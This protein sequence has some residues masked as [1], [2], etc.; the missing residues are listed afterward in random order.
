M[1]QQ[2]MFP[3]QVNSPEMLLQSAIT[4]TIQ[5]TIV[6]AGSFST[7]LQPAPNVFSVGYGE[8]S[9]LIYYPTNPT[10][11][12]SAWT[13]TNCE[14][15][16]DSNGTIGVAKTWAVNTPVSRC[17]TRLDHNRFKENI[18]DL[19]ARKIV[20]P[21]YDSIVYQ[22]GLYTIASD[23]NGNILNQ[24]LIADKN[25]H[26]PIQAAMT[27]SAAHNTG[28][29]AYVVGATVEVAAGEY[30]TKEKLTLGN[31]V[32]LRADHSA[33]FHPDL[34]SKTFAEIG[35]NGCWD[36]GM[37][38]INNTVSF[39][40]TVFVLD[41]EKYGY[42]WGYFESARIKNV[43]IRN[44]SL[45]PKTGTAI[46]LKCETYG[47]F[48]AEAGTD[49]THIVCAGLHGLVTATAY[50]QDFFWCDR[51]GVG[52]ITT[53][54]GWNDTTHTVTLATA[55]TGLVPGDTFTFAPFKGV[56]GT[57]ITNVNIKGFEY[58]ILLSVWE[59]AVQYLNTIA[60]N[61][62]RDIWF[63]GTIRPIYIKAPGKH[64]SISSNDFENIYI[65]PELTG[66][67]TVDGI[68]L[69]AGQ[70]YFRNVHTV[71]WTVN[72]GYCFNIGKKA[73]NV[74]ISGN[75]ADR[76]YIND[77]GFETTIELSD[78]NPP[79]KVLLISDAIPALTNPAT[80]SVYETAT[81]K[82]PI[83]IASF[84]AGAFR[85]VERLCWV[86][87]WQSI[88]DT[89][90]WQARLVWET[91]NES[92]LPIEFSLYAKRVG[93][94]S[95]YDVDLPL[96]CTIADVGG[97]AERQRISGQKQCGIKTEGLVMDAGTTST[98][99]VDAALSGLHIPSGSLN[100]SY[101]YNQTRTTITETSSSVKYDDLTTS[102]T[103]SSVT[104]QAQGDTYHMIRGIPFPITGTG[105]T[106]M[107][108]LRR[109]T[110]AFDTYAGTVRVIGLKLY[111]SEAGI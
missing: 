21:F 13:F 85:N 63:Y 95:T 4:S 96:V 2:V 44:S 11:S 45:T 80:I 46:H 98:V 39:D 76:S 61:S 53:T 16:Y 30:V 59:H 27:Y 32:T 25:D 5:T 10:G 19:A 26:L 43:I 14:R 42:L 50:T 97:T 67:C 3:G 99:I 110:G 86:M 83:K 49:A 71:D 52:S 22:E 8:D 57:S 9:E 106:I 70:S 55:L 15:G 69:E 36:G 88:W 18:E 29:P 17:W 77:E 6:L 12:D 105:E 47:D 33:V 72:C 94:I 79:G 89:G 101:I 81:Y 68:Y 84:Q 56:Y 38:Y 31:G 74:F 92:Y 62:I 111:C 75:C 58:G 23:K 109:S 54:T 93:D 37:I 66:T 48:V 65:E 82:R 103:V 108:E 60:W 90:K 40:G 7:K 100:G 87:P 91:S 34:G 102:L 64:C 1:T 104:N 20:Q 35:L 51:L 28:S 41:G 24:T 73:K 107:F 78:N